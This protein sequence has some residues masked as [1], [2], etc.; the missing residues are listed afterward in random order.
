MDVIVLTLDIVVVVVAVDVD[1]AGSR[2]LFM[3]RVSTPLWWLM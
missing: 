3:M 1:G 2:N